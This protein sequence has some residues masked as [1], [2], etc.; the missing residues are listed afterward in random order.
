M[1]LFLRGPVFLPF[2]ADKKKQEMS[3]LNGTIFDHFV[4]T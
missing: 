1:Q 4:T 3:G 2:L